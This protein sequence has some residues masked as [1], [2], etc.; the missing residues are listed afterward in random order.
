VRAHKEIR[1]DSY[2][3]RSNQSLV[4]RGFAFA[5]AIVVSDRAMRPHRVLAYRQTLFKW[6]VAI[7]DGPG[8]YLKIVI[9][10][11]SRLRRRAS[12]IVW[13]WCPVNRG[14]TEGR[15]CCAVSA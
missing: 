14:E 8:M 3:H 15:P 2:K 1:G 4:I 6:T 5:D 11:H 7:I 9:I 12:L 13:H 10:D